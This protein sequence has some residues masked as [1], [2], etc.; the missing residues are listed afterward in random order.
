MPLHFLVWYSFIRIFVKWRTY[1]FNGINFACLTRKVFWSLMPIF[2]SYL[3]PTSFGK[4]QDFYVHWKKPIPLINPQVSVITHSLI[5][6]TDH[7]SRM[8][9]FVIYLLRFRHKVRPHPTNEFSPQTF[10]ST[11]FQEHITCFLQ[12]VMCTKSDDT[13]VTKWTVELWARGKN[14]GVCSLSRIEFNGHYAGTT[15]HYSD[16]TLV[17][18]L[19]E[20]Q[21][22]TVLSSVSQR[23]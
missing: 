4:F 18:S 1:L 13:S 20:W 11:W 7:C 3:L 10:Y 16:Y 5:F 6:S 2:S 15:V 22:L 21:A 12:L 17:T 14:Q 19:T 9:Y 8:L 23:F